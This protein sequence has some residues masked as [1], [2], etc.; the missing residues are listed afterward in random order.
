MSPKTCRI[1]LAASVV[2]RFASIVAAPLR[3]PRMA[4]RRSAHLVEGTRSRAAS[5][6][7][8]L[9]STSVPDIPDYVDLVNEDEKAAV[10]AAL[11]RMYEQNVNPYGR[12]AESL[13][14]GQARAEAASQFWN[15]FLPGHSGPTAT[16]AIEP[17]NRGGPRIRYAPGADSDLEGGEIVRTWVPLKA[18]GGGAYDSVLILGRQKADRFYA[19]RLST[20]SHYGARRFL[21]IGAGR[22]IR[23]ADF[24]G[25]TSTTSSASTPTA[26]VEPRSSWTGTTSTVSQTNSTAATGGQWR[27]DRRSGSPPTRC[28]SRESLPIHDRRHALGG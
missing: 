5:C 2:G 9:H 3:L 4:G 16:A 23:T 24:P 14:H 26:Y 19:V 28:G 6:W 12:V 18:D 7:R 17:P 11:R 1:D 25:P 10:R 15:Q 27:T 20:T 13:V 8:V 21:P 22:R